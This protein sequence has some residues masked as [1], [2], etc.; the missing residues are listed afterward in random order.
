MPAPTSDP[1][2]VRTDDFDGL[3]RASCGEGDLDEAH[4][5][6]RSAFPA[7]VAA[8]ASVPRMIT[9][10][11]AVVSSAAMSTAMWLTALRKS[12]RGAATRGAPG[13][14][15]FVR[16]RTACSSISTPL[17]RTG[18]PLDVPVYEPERCLVRDIAE[19]LG[20]LVV[21]DAYALLLDQIVGHRKPTC[22]QAASASG[23]SGQCGAS[24]TS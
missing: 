22:R 20:A 12:R 24:C 13:M 23:P 9:I 16:V 1:F 3:G 4:A 6:L 19:R 10:T 15:T 21:V 14:A 2:G 17:P 5:L 11:R 8:A 7:A 18:E